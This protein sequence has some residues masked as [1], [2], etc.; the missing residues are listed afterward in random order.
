MTASAPSDQ[1]TATSKRSGQRCRHLVIGGGVCHL[2]GGKSPAVAAKREARIAVWEAQQGEAPIEVRDPGEALLAAATLADELVQRLHRDVQERG[3][4]TPAN[5]S[6]LGE[7]LDRVGRLSRAVIDARIDERRVRLAEGQGH[8]IATLLRDVL[9]ELGHDVSPGSAAA[10]VVVRH[11]RA[12]AE[13][14]RGAS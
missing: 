10:Q 5:L 1:C 12:V 3:V 7:S 14:E 4:L 9:V 8:Q 2:H 11:L 6:A 13:L